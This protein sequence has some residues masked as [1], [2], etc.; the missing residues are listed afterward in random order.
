M[1]QSGTP[2]QLIAILLQGRNVRGASDGNGDAIQEHGS[3]S[4]V[5]AAAGR[6]QDL[7]SD[8]R[9]WNRATGFKKLPDRVTPRKSA[10]PKTRKGTKRKVAKTAT[11][12]KH[13]RE[14]KMTWRFTVLVAMLMAILESILPAQTPQCITLRIEL[15]GGSNPPRD[16]RTN[17]GKASVGVHI[18]DCM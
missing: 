3:A 13:P 16:V 17:E 4:E 1:A 12:Y 7:G 9:G 18:K 10:K 8:L 14:A 11:G 2:T 5:C 6:G 15:P